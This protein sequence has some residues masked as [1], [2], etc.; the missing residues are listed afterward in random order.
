MRNAIKNQVFVKLQK[1]KSNTWYFIAFEVWHSVQLSMLYNETYRLPTFIFM[2]NVFLENWLLFL[3]YTLFITCTGIWK[4]LY[5]SKW[6][7]FFFY[8]PLFLICFFVILISFF[9]LLFLLL[10]LF[11]PFV[12]TVYVLSTTKRYSGMQRGVRKSHK[13]T[14]W[15]KN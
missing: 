9:V 3:S 10:P 1:I 14:A 2:T 7:R 4:S 15:W 12:L 13:D 6:M 5:L 8:F 11:I